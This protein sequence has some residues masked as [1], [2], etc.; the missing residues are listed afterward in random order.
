MIA[1]LARILYGLCVAAVGIVA[2]FAPVHVS[3]QELV[4][5]ALL[6]IAILVTDGLDR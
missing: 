5:L 6:G 4:G 3:L 2:V 1:R